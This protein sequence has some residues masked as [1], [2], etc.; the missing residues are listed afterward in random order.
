[1]NKEDLMKLNTKPGRIYRKD[2]NSEV[3]YTWIAESVEKIAKTMA[4]LRATRCTD[5]LIIALI[6]DHT[7]VGKTE[8]EQ[9]LKSLATLDKVYLK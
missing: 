6:H 2:I 5:K 8:I 7:K 9:V 4:E 3:P 1:M